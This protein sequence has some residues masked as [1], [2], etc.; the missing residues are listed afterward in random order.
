[1]CITQN[2]KY[3]RLTVAYNNAKYLLNV[4]PFDENM[5]N[6][7]VSR[8][9]KHAANHHWETDSKVNKKKN[10]FNN[11]LKNMQCYEIKITTFCV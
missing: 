3:L 8:D 5:C 10:W 4:I 9:H 6:Q 2:K 1:M 11:D 7:Q